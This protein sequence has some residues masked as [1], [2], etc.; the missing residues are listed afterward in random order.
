MKLLSN[1]PELVKCLNFDSDG[2]YEISPNY[3]RDVLYYQMDDSEF[4]NLAN[5]VKNISTAIISD[6]DVL[7]FDKKASFPKLLLKQLNSKIT[8]TI[9]K[10]KS[11]KIVVNSES[12]LTSREI[13]NADTGYLVLVGGT[14]EV[15]YKKLF[16]ISDN[17]IE[18]IVKKGLTLENMQLCFQGEWVRGVCINN[19]A[20]QEMID[21]INQ[22]F[23]KITTVNRVAVYLNSKLPKLDEESKKS[24]ISLFQG[25]ASCKAMALKLF[26]SYNMSDAI[27]DVCEAIGTSREFFDQSS[28]N[29]I[30]YKYLKTLLGINPIELNKKWRW[31]YYWSGQLASN[32]FHNEILSPE[33]KFKAWS[34]FYKA[35][36]Q[37]STITALEE[38]EKNYFDNY[39]MPYSYDQNGTSNS[40]N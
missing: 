24:L 4:E 20:T 5:N 7:Y 29:S 10:D 25:D 11:T 15:L 14:E 28:K 16:F 32:L 12:I 39:N 30:N 17:D 31:R 6:E 27:F 2:I 3:N 40:G 21:Y 38:S 9:K 13:R 18:D 37:N 35:V 1:N 26:V 23:T 34:K 8:R 36:T 19:K 33:Q 22:D